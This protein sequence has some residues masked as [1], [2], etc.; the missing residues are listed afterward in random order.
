[1]QVKTVEHLKKREQKKADKEKAKSTKAA[2]VS[3]FPLKINF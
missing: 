1:M 3:D 2:D